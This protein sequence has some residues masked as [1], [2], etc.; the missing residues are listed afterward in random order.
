VVAK[1]THEFRSNYF[2]RKLARHLS[3]HLG[4]P[5]HAS[6]AAIATVALDRGAPEELTPDDVKRALRHQE[7]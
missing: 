7:G 3:A 1:M 2:I 5:M 6:L 4:G